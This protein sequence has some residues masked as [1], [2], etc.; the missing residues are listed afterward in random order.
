MS[1]NIQ[2]II[3]KYANDNAYLEVFA[4]ALK[5]SEM[6]NIDRW[7]AFNL[8]KGER[9]I[10]SFGNLRGVLLPEDET[11]DLLDTTEP[12]FDTLYRWCLGRGYESNGTIS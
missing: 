10:S 4:Y 7:D 2:Q 6:E 12:F 3:I 11:D 9:L 1:N 5:F 8:L